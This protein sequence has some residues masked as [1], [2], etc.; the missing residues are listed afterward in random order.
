MRAVLGY[1]FQNT[2]RRKPSCNL[3]LLPV[4]PATP[5]SRLHRP[6]ADHGD[7]GQ[8]AKR[9]VQTAF[10][11]H[12]TTAGPPEWTGN[13]L[14]RSLPAC[15]VACV[16][17]IKFA[18]KHRVAQRSQNSNRSHHLIHIFSPYPGKAYTLYLES[19]KRCSAC[20][21]ARSRAPTSNT[22]LPAAWDLA[23]DICLDRRGPA[24]H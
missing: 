2:T 19:R 14:R 8:Q 24:Y 15:W 18:C 13:R 1:R 7:P 22:A 3:S 17:C 9:A 11:P 6:C 21:D 16:G 23:L 4:H 10:S 5:P 20:R 12:F